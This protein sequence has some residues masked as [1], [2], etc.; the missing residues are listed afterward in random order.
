MISL[1]RTIQTLSL[2]AFL[3]LL[4]LAFFPVPDW[5][6]VDAFLRLDPL[7][8]VGTVL[9]DRAW[10]AALAPAA[11]VLILTL[12]LGRFFCGYLCPMGTTLDITDGLA[13]IPGSAGKISTQD[14]PAAPVLPPP[15]QP[16]SDLRRIKYLI[17]FFILGAAVL[18]VSAVFFA[19]PLS[20][21]TRFYTLLIHPAAAL[22][23]DAALH[24]LR[25]LAL[26]LD[27]TRAAYAEL[28]QPR[29]TTQ[30]FLLLFF[31][32]VFSLARWSPRFWCRYLCPTGALLALVGRRP[33]IRRTVSDV[34]TDCGACQRRC[35]MAAIPANPSRTIHE[36]CIA[37]Q[38]CV[39]I[40]PVQA[41]TFQP[42]HESGKSGASGARTPG[43]S[44]QRREVLLAGLAGAGTAT[45]TYTG[46]LEVRGEMLPG[47]ITPETLLRPPGSLPERDFLAR[48]IRCGLCMRACPTN[49]LQP[50]WFEAGVIAL[51]S[52]RLTPRRGPCEPEC[53]ACGRV[54][55]TGAIRDLPLADKTWAKVGTATILRHKC[56]AW[57]WNKK[58]LVCD[59]VCPY[60]AID[61]RRVATHSQPVP[62]V[63]GRKCSGCGFC[64]YHCPVRAASAII[65]EP[66][67]AL[68]LGAG[69]YKAKGQN[70]GLMLHVVPPDQTGYVPFD[71]ETPDTALAPLPDAVPDKDAL[72]PGFTP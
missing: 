9:A 72:P 58:C 18:G 26:H 43:F 56:L 66:M 10:V 69:S 49:T 34:C 46:L 21:I 62:F 61:L 15:S 16:S 17:L 45:L 60:D 20:L 68:R 54:C 22:F 42:S 48:C 19:S 2:A 36:E 6:P 50:I 64:E 5:A 38:K 11:L 32:A 8:L 31:L 39:R 51:F 55:P 30:W 12:A 33:L 14:D 23:G 27:W 25:P 41:V 7:V 63:D 53:T 47:D 1:Q 3:V 40:C 65:V 29:F 57:E 13:R 71:L 4:G 28:H 37:C 52:P 59:E 67:E 70:M 35:P 44:P 24:A